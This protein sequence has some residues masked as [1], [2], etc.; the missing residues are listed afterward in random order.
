[1][2]SPDREGRLTASDHAAALGLNPYCSRQELWRRWNGLADPISE[3]TQAR[4]DWGHLHEAD[5]LAAFESETGQIVTHCL[6]RQLFVPYEDW[7]GATPDGFVGEDGILECKCPTRI[8]DEPPMYYWVQIQ[9]Q[10]VFTTRSEGFLSAW[11]PDES[12]IWRTPLLSNYWSEAN[13]IL[14][15]CWTNLRGGLEPKRARKPTFTWSP[16]WERIA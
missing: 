11:T 13:T 9:S 4:F 5:A 3:E 1:M 2:L 12:A 6:D 8:W 15:A 16:T 10:L 14:K 7:S